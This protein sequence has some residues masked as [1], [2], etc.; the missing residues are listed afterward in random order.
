MRKLLTRVRA[1]GW[2]C[3]R[4]RDHKNIESV[5]VVKVV[6]DRYMTMLCNDCA[7]EVVDCFIVKEQMD[8]ACDVCPDRFRCLTRTDAVVEKIM[9]SV[10]THEMSS[11]PGVIDSR[12]IQGV[13][14][15]TGIYN[16]KLDDT[17]CAYSE[18]DD[19]NHSWMRQNYE[20]SPYKRC[21]Y[22]KYHVQNKV[23]YC[24]FGRS[25]RGEI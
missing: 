10:K 8:A 14:S 7:T 9:R 5:D 24:W 13:R 19:C 4:C 18:R 23:W 25:K 15:Y 16:S 1:Y 20:G 21:I 12:N 6:G 22:M 3:P 17:F 11:V 2:Y